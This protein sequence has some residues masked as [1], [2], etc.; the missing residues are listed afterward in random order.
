MFWF[1]ENEDGTKE[2]MFSIWDDYQIASV[3]V[4]FYLSNMSQQIL[5]DLV[6]ISFLND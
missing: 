1:S 4:S 2:M 3:P 5:S 6:P